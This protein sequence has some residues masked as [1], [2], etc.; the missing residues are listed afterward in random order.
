MTNEP[1]FLSI[2]YWHPCGNFDCRHSDHWGCFPVPIVLSAMA[3]MYWTTS[4][5]E[6]QKRK[7]KKK[8]RWMVKVLFHC[9]RP[10]RYV[11]QDF[12]KLLFRILT[13][14]YYMASWMNQRGHDE[15][16]HALWL[17]V[18]KWAR[19]CF[20][21]QLGLLTVYYKKIV[22]FVH[23][24]INPLFIKLVWSR[25]LD[26]D[27]IRFLCVYGP[28]YQPWWPHAWPRTQ[29]SSTFFQHTG[30]FVVASCATVS[31]TNPSDLK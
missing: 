31:R 10:Y 24:L 30:I 23:K 5:T 7:V 21:A 25:W 1:W 8:D 18:P 27:L 11:P 12:P 3:M 16:N 2:K 15:L 6:M 20:L 4:Y 9:S 28:Q 13:P 19:W 22:L 14:I 29:A 17:A 26:I